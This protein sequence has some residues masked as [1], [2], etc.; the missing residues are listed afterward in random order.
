MNLQRRWMGK[1]A[2]LV[3]AMLG[4]LG[5]ASG[6]AYSQNTNSIVINNQPLANRSITVTEVNAA[7]NGWVT[8]HLDENN[9]PGRVLGFS[10]IK[11]GKNSNVVIQLSE[12]VPVGTKVWAMLHIDAGTIGTWEFPG[13]DAPVIVNGDIVM[14]QITI[15]ESSTTPAA[16]PSTG[17]T[18]A[19]AMV[20]LLVSAL[21]LVSLGAVLRRMPGQR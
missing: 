18:D 2:L 6:V 13:P 16:L 7:Q 20:V 1:V 15:T 5:L 14:Q 9:S 12:A 10:A 3:L 4:G 8:C 21:L 19:T 11:V 17:G